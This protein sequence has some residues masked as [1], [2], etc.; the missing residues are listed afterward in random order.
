M[1][2]SLDHRGG[3][4]T[5]PVR[6]NRCIP[7]RVC[8]CQL[9]PNLHAVASGGL[10]AGISSG[11]QVHQL[12]LRQALYDGNGAIIY[13]TDIA[14]LH[15][16]QHQLCLHRYPEHRAAVLYG[17]LRPHLAGYQ[18]HPDMPQLVILQG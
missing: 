13:G 15:F 4:R 18:F 6:F 1:A 12:L 2:D 14:L 5:V 17:A 10:Q 9:R 16:V 8:H 3:E 11:A 7:R